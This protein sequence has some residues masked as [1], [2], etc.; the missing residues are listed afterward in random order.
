MI[1]DGLKDCS[2]AI[3]GIRDGIGAALKP[4]HFVERTW[5]GGEPGS[6]TATDVKELM[7]NTPHIVDLS[8]NFRALQGGNVKQGDLLLKMVD[9]Q[10]HPRERFIPA[11]GTRNKEQFLMIGDLLYTVISMRERSLQWD[12][13]IRPASD[14]RKYFNGD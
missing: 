13:Q 12:V 1:I 9:K 2:D 6:G 11:K 14:Q 8:Q 3:L 5:S 10:R 4:V 7:A